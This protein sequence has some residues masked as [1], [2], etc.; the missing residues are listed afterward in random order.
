MSFR[1]SFQVRIGRW[2]FAVPS[3]AKSGAGG[4]KPLGSRDIAQTEEVFQ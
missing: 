3:A 4:R 1:L 2:K